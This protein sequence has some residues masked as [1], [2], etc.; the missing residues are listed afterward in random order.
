MKLNEQATFWLDSWVNQKTNANETAR[1]NAKAIALHIAA[2]QAR[3]GA[4]LTAEEL[5]VAEPKL[6]SRQ[7]NQRYSQ[8]V[9]VMLGDIDRIQIALG[10][11]SDYLLWLNLK[12]HRRGAIDTASHL[13]NEARELAYLLRGLAESSQSDRGAKP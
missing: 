7:Y 2:L 3:L 4:P 5:T 12:G 9:T 10:A 1:A 13:V 6:P 8:K 11:A